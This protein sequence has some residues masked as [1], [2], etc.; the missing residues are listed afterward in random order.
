MKK[1][2]KKVLIEQWPEEIEF[3][4]VSE[5]FFVPE[6]SV[7]PDTDLITTVDVVAAVSYSDVIKLNKLLARYYLLIYISLKVIVVSTLGYNNC[8]MT[9]NY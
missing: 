1:D 8:L 5:I 3:R 9:T 2:H 4:Q 6:M 7:G